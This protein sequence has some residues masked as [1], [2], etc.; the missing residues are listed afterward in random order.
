M[1]YCACRMSAHAKPRSPFG[2]RLRLEL[3]DAGL[4]IR[5]LSKRLNQGQPDH[6]RRNLTRWLANGGNVPTRSNRQAVA[7]ALGLDPSTFDEDDDEEDAELSGLIRALMHQVGVVV[8]RRLEE[9]LGGV[10]A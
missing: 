10:P 3:D 6:A 1:G 8:D 2:Q 7:V 4:S 5:E 9:R